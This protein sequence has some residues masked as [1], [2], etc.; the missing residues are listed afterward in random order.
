MRNL[1]LIGKISIINTL[2][3]PLFVYPMSVLPSVPQ[4]LIDD[5]N[6][7]F[8]HFIWNGHKPK[9]PL[10]ILQHPKE[11]G[12]LALVDLKEKNESLK[13]AWV[14]HLYDDDK[15]A[16]LAHHIIQKDLN[17][18]IWTCNLKPEDIDVVAN[19]N[20]VGAFWNDVLK[21]WAKHNFS[22]EL[23]YN[24][25]LW[26]NS[27]I[28]AGNAPLL[29][30]RAVSRGLW[31]VRD[32]VQNG[33]FISDQEAQSLYGLS[34]MEYNTILC[35]IPYKT[36]CFAKSDK[37]RGRSDVGI[38]ADVLLSDCTSRIF[39]QKGHVTDK[40]LQKKCEQWHAEIGYVMQEEEFCK[41]IR[42][43]YI[44]TN[45]PKYR[46]FQYRLMY[47]AIITNIQLNHW[48]MVDS[49]SCSF[50]GSYR[51]SYQH[52][53]HNCIIIRELW[54]KVY[55]HFDQLEH[56][57]LESANILLNQVV[58]KPNHVNNFI[59]L[60]IK[61]YIYRCRCLKKPIIFHEAYALIK[62]VRAMERYI[63]IKNGKSNLHEAKWRDIPN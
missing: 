60:V 54:T 62:R 1:S 63:A 6:K 16:N 53:F 12:G 4:K 17:F 49:D 18:R 58:D 28:R 35:A 39:Y 48:G 20:R 33:S 41:R 38:V 27:L 2:V 36:K 32:L 30:L 50:C 8:I 10:R 42:D 45:V 9:I 52:L 57:N 55:E 25:S 5:M 61:Q 22:E 34:T 43:I 15:A 13:M 59:C 44:I 19:R 26:W 3:A 29:N 31:T 23:E 56:V 46:S 7:E 51:E 24:H 37:L 11:K 14:K 47:R 21:K 40:L